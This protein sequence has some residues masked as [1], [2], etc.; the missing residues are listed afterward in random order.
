M[1]SKVWQFI[2]DK[3]AD[4]QFARLDKPIQRRIIQATQKI[5]NAPNPK[6]LAKQL[7]GSK[8]QFWRYRVGTHRIIVRFE[9]QHLII[10]AVK[11]AHRK[12][13]YT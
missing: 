7:T 2:F 11:I 6:S 4:K 3:T 8:A 9:D 1:A 13:V 10:L 12:N 5:L